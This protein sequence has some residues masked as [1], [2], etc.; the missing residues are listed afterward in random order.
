MA[1]KTVYVHANVGVTTRTKLARLID[2][3]RLSGNGACIM[4]IDATS[5][6]KAAIP[7]IVSHYLSTHVAQ[8]HHMRT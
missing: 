5:Q 6:S 1:A 8:Q 4:T 7:G 3:D 2:G